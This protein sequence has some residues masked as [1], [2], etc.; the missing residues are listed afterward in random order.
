MTPATAQ[1]D[2][3]HEQFGIGVALSMLLADLIDEAWVNLDE[4]YEANGMA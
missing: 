2:D 3:P 1:S 4:T